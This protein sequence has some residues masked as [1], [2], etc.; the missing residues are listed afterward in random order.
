MFYQHNLPSSVDNAAIRSGQNYA[1]WHTACVS[2]TERIEWKSTT[3]VASLLSRTMGLCCWLLVLTAAASVL[4]MNPLTEFLNEQVD[5]VLQSGELCKFSEKD[6]ACDDHI[7]SINMWSDAEWCCCPQFYEGY[8]TNLD[9]GIR[10]TGDCAFDPHNTSMAVCELSFANVEL[11][12]RWL[13]LRRNPMMEG[14]VHLAHPDELV[15]AG[16]LTV[17]L[18]EGSGLLLLE[19]DVTDGMH[20]HA[21]SFDTDTIKI[22]KLVFNNSTISCDGEVVDTNEKVF[23]V[24]LQKALAERIEEYVS[25][26]GFLDTFNEALELVQ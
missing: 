12:Y 11:H 25:G 24:E 7:G 6:G 22:G 9:H 26:D 4:A 13:L 2:S 5:Y 8:V 10:R 1:Q 21:T 15:D 14:N 20:Y 17:T 18:A 19:E 16:N 23:R 3:S